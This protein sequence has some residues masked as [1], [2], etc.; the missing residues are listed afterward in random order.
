MVRKIFI[1]YLTETM[2]RSAIVVFWVNS[3][4]YRLGGRF[5][6]ILK[7]PPSITEYLPNLQRTKERRT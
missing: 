4:N 5:C 7:F 2:V 1:S 3:F 6:Q